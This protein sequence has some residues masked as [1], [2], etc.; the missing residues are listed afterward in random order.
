MK[1]WFGKLFQ[2]LTIPTK[3]EY[4]KELTL[5]NLVCILYKQRKRSGV[6]RFRVR[7]DIKWKFRS[8][9]R[10][11]Y[12]VDKIK[13]DSLLLYSKQPS[14]WFVTQSFPILWEDLRSQAF[15]SLHRSP[16]PR[17]L[18]ENNRNV[19]QE[20]KGMWGSEKLFFVVERASLPW[21]SLHIHDLR[22][23]KQ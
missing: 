5:A 10:K 1:R 9:P 15:F 21:S 2:P 14:V 6:F 17:T 20:K 12:W 4:L 22:G 19:E 8:L 11:Y 7:K 18:R 23:R 16:Q 3:K 13:E